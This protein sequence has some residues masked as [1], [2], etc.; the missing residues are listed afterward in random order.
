MLKISVE[1]ISLLT[2]YLY[3]LRKKELFQQNQYKKDCTYQTLLE[4]AIFPT[5]K[6]IYR[7]RNYIKILVNEPICPT[8][9]TQFRKREI[10]HLNKYLIFTWKTNCSRSKGKFLI[11]KKSKKKLKKQKTKQKIC[12]TSPKKPNF[13][14]KNNFL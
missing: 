1:Y 11:L 2:I 12:Y 6:Q 4:G 13:P 7:K 5:T 9:A 8:K 3:Y 14:N 10:F